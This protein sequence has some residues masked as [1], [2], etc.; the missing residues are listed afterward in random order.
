MFSYYVELALRSLRQSPG[1]TLLMVLAIGFGVSASM[2]TYSVFR[3]VSGD[4]IPNKSSKLFTPQ[5]DAWGP[6]QNAQGEPPGALSYTDAMALMRAHKANRQTLLYA[7]HVSVMPSGNRNLPLSANGYA[8]YGDF[9]SMFEVPF[10]YGSGWGTDDDDGRASLVVL[11]EAF[12]QK[13]FGGVD[14]VGKEITLNGH[15]YR[16][17]GVAQHWN[18]QPRFFAAFDGNSFDEAS[19]FYLPFTRALDLQI[20]TYGRINCRR[21]TDFPTR[22]AW[23]NSDC[24]WAMPWVELDSAVDAAQYK[25]FLE[26]Y[27]ADQQRAGRFSWAPNVRLRNVKEWLDFEH[28]VPPETRI[29][30]TIAIGFFIIC[31][32]NTVGLLLAKFMRRAGEIGIRR[33]LGAPRSEIYK[34]FLIEAGMVGLAGGVLG[35]FLTV[36]DMR[37]VVLLF[38][39]VIARLAHL[40]ASLI[41]MTFLTAIIA[42]VLAASYPAWRAAHIRPAWQ[43]KLS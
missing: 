42:T 33:A 9:F 29:S 38:E 26:S 28:V 22:D 35:L 43:L 24:V 40:D 37:V 3:A 36:L 20:D 10:R 32:V 17:V 23:L 7:V 19:D 8:V 31:L 6:G 41:A 34:Q 4:P 18:P 12:N 11:S 13:I 5:I 1:L 16:V 2:T 27:A 15:E 30:L 39:P 25:R 14:S 21:T